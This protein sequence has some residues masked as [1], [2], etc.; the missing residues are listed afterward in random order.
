MLDDVV[1]AAVATGWAV[2]VVTDARS[3]AARARAA[4]AQAMIVRARGT[5]DGARRGIV[6][7]L[8]G[9]AGAVLIVAADVPMVRAVDLRRVAHAGRS[10]D[11]VI[12][13]DRRQ[14]GTNALYLRPPSRMAPRFGPG[15]LG[16]HRTAAGVH[17]R[18][19]PVARLA[20]D[21]DTP[22]DLE[23]LRRQKRRAGPRTRA[24]LEHED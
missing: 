16:A 22:A 1:A 2:L 19:L 10:S 4:G 6:R 8:R 3:S 15:S 11:V 18:T 9:G 23:L 12:V 14:S 17:G 5:R 21:V 20:L 24:A 7:A 13:P